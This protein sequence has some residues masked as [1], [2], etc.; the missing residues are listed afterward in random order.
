MQ[1]AYVGAVAD[2][3]D[4]PH[5][6]RWRATYTSAWMRQPLT[7]RPDRL[8]AAPCSIRGTVAGAPCRWRSGH[9]RIVE[10]ELWFWRH[11]GRRT[12]PLRFETSTLRVDSQRG[13]G[14]LEMF[15]LNR[16]CT[17]L[18]CASVG[19]EVLSIALMYGSDIA[20]VTA[21]LALT[22]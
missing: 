4:G 16:R 21:A 14:L 11:L 5:G 20:E 22:R 17:V 10:D 15:W 18:E 1:L 12:I 9:L 2:R 7:A 3:P 19:D 8:E 6:P 13:V